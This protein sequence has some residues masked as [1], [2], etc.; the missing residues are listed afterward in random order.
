M[1]SAT[2]ASEVAVVSYVFWQSHYGGARD[3]IGKT[4][5]IEGIPFTIIGVT[6]KG[7]RGMSAAGEME[8]HLPPPADQLCGGEPDMQKYLRRRNARWLQA[9]GRLKPGVTLERARADLD[10]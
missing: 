6:G 4:L 2:A 8:G 1:L 3:I 5:K 7:F 9:A 10:S